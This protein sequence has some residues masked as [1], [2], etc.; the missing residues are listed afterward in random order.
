[1]NNEKIWEKN[2]KLNN[3]QFCF[4]KYSYNLGVFFGLCDVLTVL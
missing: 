2:H 1:M 3:A 4:I